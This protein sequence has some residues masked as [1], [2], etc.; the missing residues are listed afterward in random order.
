MHS[1]S[2]NYYP[3]G[4]PE[5]WFGNYI[6]DEALKPNR[7]YFI[8]I[9]TQFKLKKNKLPFIQIKDNLL[10]N[11]TDSLETSDIY[12]SRDGK[13][14]EYYQDL[15]GNIRT[16]SVVL[17]LT[18]TDY[19]L[20]KEHY[21]LYNTEILSGCWFYAEKGIFDE[22][23]DKY[24]TIKQESKGAI[25]ML[26]KLMMN[27]LYGKF[28][29]STYN[30][31]K[32]A[33]MRDDE[34]LGFFIVPCNDKKP[35]YIPVGSAIT[36]YARCFTIR[37]AQAN[38]Y[39]KDKHGFIYADTDSIHCDL[40]PEKIKGI[41]IHET[42]FCCWKI[43]NEWDIGYFERQKTYIEHTVKEDMNPIEEPYYNIKCA[44]MPDRCKQQFIDGLINGTYK[45]EDFTIGL[46]LSGKLLPK[47]IKGGTILV[48]TTY[49]MR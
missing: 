10:Y 49:E 42:D 39:G 6:P 13:Y 41:S 19:E 43:E 15:D 2:G 25:R 44:G 48:D 20:I 33:Y 28:A 32:V 23:I 7:Y 47:R 14:Y 3:V 37:A 30:S 11:S 4:Y 24:K 12:S 29:T 34:S 40:P 22:Y 35:I 21:N 9:R 45:L 8:R 16:A 46:T 26:A 36:S 31:F 27:S 1:Q 17:T 18:M 5:F 38:Y